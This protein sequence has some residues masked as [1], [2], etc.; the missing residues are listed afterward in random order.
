[1][2][3]KKPKQVI[4]TH[5]NADF[6]A[7]S[8]MLAAKKLYPDAKLIFPGSQER[9]IKN[10]FLS[11]A[12]YLFDFLRPKD[13]DLSEIK[14]VII[15]D[16]RQKSRIGKFSEIVE[17]GDVEVHI[18]DH[19]PP[20]E[21]DIKGDL[22]VIKRV[23]ANTTIMVQILRE[24]GI[25]VTP[26]EATIMCLGIHEDT[27]S[28]TFSST[29]PEDY[30]AACWLA[31]HGADH[32]LISN[33]LTRE[34]TADHISLLNE[35]IESAKRYVIDGKK[36]V[37][38][39]VIR[40]EYIGDFA[41]LV[42][43]FMEMDNI[44]VVFALAQM[45]DR[46][47]IVARSRIDQIDVSEIIKEFGGGGHPFA[48]SAT[49][50]G[51]P[52]NQLENLLIESI[53]KHIGSK[54]KRAK[55]IMSS[56]VISISPD[57]TLEKAEELMNRF[58]INVL[59]VMK[60]GRLLG[61]IT[62][63]VVDRAR[64]FHLEKRKVAEYMTNEY[65]SVH[66]DA[67]IKEVQ[68]IIIKD[69]ARILPVIKDGRVVGVI[70]R[71]D[72]L[73]LFLEDPYRK[74]LFEE[75]KYA[76]TKDLKKL[77]K[78]M[79]P[80]RIY[81]LLEEFGKTAESLGYNAYVVGGFVRDLIL[82]RRNLDIDIVIEG[83]GIRF[84]REFAKRFDVKINVHKRF[85]TAYIIFPDGFKVDVATARMEYYESPG[86]LPVVKR[87][88]LKL[89]LYRR[90]FTINTLAIKLNSSE[91]GKL[92]DYFNGMRDIKDGIIRVLHN[93]SFIEDPSRILRAIRFEQRFGF[94]IGKLTLSL[95][96]NA[97][98]INCF[99]SIAGK[100][101]FHELKL[102]LMEDDPLKAIDRMNELNVLSSIS[103]LLRWSSE[104]R[105][106]FEDIRKTIAW[107]NLLFLEEKIEGWV[108]YWHG[109]I[110]HLKEEE[111]RKI[112]ERFE[113]DDK[114]LIRTAEQ[115]RHIEDAS[116]KII[117]DELSNYQIY[118]L[119]SPYDIEM[120]LYV[121][122]VFQN[123]KLRRAISN[124]FTKLKDVRPQLRGKD[125]I[126][127][128][129]KPGPIFG[130]I[131]EELLEARMNEVVKSREDEIKFVEERYLRGK[132]V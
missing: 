20:S 111:I 4:I 44:D 2:D 25:H 92:I 57:E 127:M 74:D 62:R 48:A 100:R 36:I 78:E 75:R 49:V 99:D 54:T 10:F 52:L 109:L 23:G 124:Y 117:T 50:K 69:R 18:Y 132:K 32:N 73:N 29:T 121:M 66:P 104:H 119:L 41:V 37:V 51:I 94:R 63:Q 118:K 30:E 40:D 65:P 83:D 84:A 97:I 68:D 123:E 17:K 34:L 35:L 21:D 86:A 11:S 129:L 125:L 38:S 95:I 108:I 14:R 33:L 80:E 89:D 128:G 79:L 114:K 131:L 28:F 60:E 87:S 93:L 31:R 9:G 113:I 101:L 122:A 106:I 26:D 56:P 59:L 5:L 77:L 71:T 126:R 105:R 47:L 116:R 76:F 98:K 61:Y 88:S 12:S 22:E 24:R 46:I 27:G 55:D 58:S 107:Y 64:Y 15:V 6:D 115:R 96:K 1:M 120:L 3:K 85:R 45:E 19:H 8:S 110:S 130:K 70:T 43:R 82:R 7:L 39:K 112:Y 72:I 103:P 53:R 81:S 16:T 102:I 91:F 67:S 13:I 90:D 42:Q